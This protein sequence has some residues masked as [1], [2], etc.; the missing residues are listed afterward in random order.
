MKIILRL[1]ATPFVF[2]LILITH[3]YYVFHRTYWF[4]RYGG[5]YIGYEPNDRATIK[6]LYL[7][8]QIA[9]LKDD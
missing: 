3:L 6:D 4:I 8:L 7:E 1:L 9:R 5:E 2:G